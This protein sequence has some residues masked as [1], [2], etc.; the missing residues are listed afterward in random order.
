MFSRLFRLGYSLGSNEINRKSVRFYVIAA[1][2]AEQLTSIPKLLSLPFRF[3]FILFR[4]FSILV[5]NKVE[6]IG[7]IHKHLFTLP[8]GYA[9]YIVQTSEPD[10]K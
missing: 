3:K 1:Q 7:T 10:N 9:S 8:S 5:I 2:S 6:I 4:F